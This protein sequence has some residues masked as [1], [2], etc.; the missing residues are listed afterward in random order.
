MTMTKTMTKT[1]IVT[2]F[3][4]PM[5]TPIATPRLKRHNPDNFLF[6]KVWNEWGEGNYMEPDDKYG[7]AYI[8]A[9]GKAFK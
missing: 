9:A 6:I 5:M 2:P 7:K 1:P 3:M 4:I 8:E